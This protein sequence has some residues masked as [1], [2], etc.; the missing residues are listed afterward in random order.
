VYADGNIFNT[1]KG[2]K[3]SAKR[4]IDA[5][6]PFADVRLVVPYRAFVP[7]TVTTK[8]A[9]GQ[10]NQITKTKEVVQDVIVDK[11]VME[12]HTT[13]V[14]PFT[15]VDY[16]KDE[17]PEEHRFYPET[18]LPIFKRYIAGTREHIQWPWEFDAEEYEN[19]VKRDEYL[20]EKS[21][22][23]G[24]DAQP[25]KPKGRLGKTVAWVKDKT[26]ATKV[27]LSKQAQADL[28][29]EKER[30]R[31]E[32]EA[33]AFEAALEKAS[34]QSYPAK[35]DPQ[36][37]SD[38]AEDTSRNLA[39]VSSQSRS[40]YPT[41][42]YPPFPNELADELASDIR[43]KAWA[44]AKDKS[45]VEAAEE[46]KRQRTEM[47]LQAKEAKERE[48]AVRQQVMMTPMQLRWEVERE[49]KLR[50]EKPLV[51]KEVLLAALGMHMSAKGVRL[52]EKRVR[53]AESANVD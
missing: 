36:L 47:Y 19:R 5:P 45:D 23:D 12:R 14:D 50:E 17:F 9:D 3:K 2:E 10:T 43:V 4:E 15:N 35:Q 41:L 42:M 29:A 46:R 21:A 44:D 16:G 28:N 18:G 38:G 32:R 40:F 27:A 51:Q 30:A 7:Y 31:D 1:P 20:H 33:A 53:A 8:D 52:D 39:E 37:P 25:E 13:G 11:I 6:V 26:T 48:G 24:K 34:K 49:R 22:K